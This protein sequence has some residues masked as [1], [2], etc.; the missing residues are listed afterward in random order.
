M[1]LRPAGGEP[2]ARAE[3]TESTRHPSPELSSQQLRAA[4][5]YITPPPGRGP[6]NGRRPTP[7]LPSP[8]FPASGFHRRS[9]KTGPARPE[10]RLGGREGG[11]GGQRG[12]TSEP[13][14][15]RTARRGVNRRS[16]PHPAVMGAGQGTRI[17]AICKSLPGA[18]GGGWR[19][20]RS[21]PLLR[22]ARPRAPRAPGGARRSLRF[23]PPP[24][25]ARPRAARS[26]AVNKCVGA[27]HAAVLPPRLPARI[28]RPAS[29][30]AR[31]VSASH[32]N[33]AASAGSRGARRPRGDHR[34]SRPPPTPRPS[35]ATGA[36]RSRLA[37][38]SPYTPCPELPSS[39]T[40]SSPSSPIATSIF[41]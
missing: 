32:G 39:R 9:A 27:R 7:S 23:S 37:P 17:P 4:A 28:P 18:E 19:F 40:V 25:A 35:P 21:A 29:R 8:V 41:T 34:T 12:G 6:R 22:A 26:R 38:H 20:Q 14:V 36:T 2:G 5:A 10:G 24:L 16:S 3:F 1:H 31:A 33:G 13:A 30:R 11:E 15:P